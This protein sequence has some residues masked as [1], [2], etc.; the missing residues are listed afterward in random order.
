VIAHNTREARNTTAQVLQVGFAPVL[1]LRSSGTLKY[2][3]IE[4]TISDVRA[5]RENI[6]GRAV[7]PH[8]HPARTA[9]ATQIRKKPVD[10]LLQ[11]FQRCNLVAASIVMAPFV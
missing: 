9:L 4:T 2:H 11:K 8:E 3:H 1:S 5:S 10:V 7:H 6:S